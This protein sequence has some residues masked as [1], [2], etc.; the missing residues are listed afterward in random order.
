MR[1]RQLTSI[2]SDLQLASERDSNRKCLVF[3]QL[4]IASTH[5]TA[6]A[7]CRQSGQPGEPGRG[8]GPEFQAFLSFRARE[9]CKDP[10]KL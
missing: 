4:R 8:P 5:G 7:S 1:K 2:I 10:R 6:A 9:Q 3:L